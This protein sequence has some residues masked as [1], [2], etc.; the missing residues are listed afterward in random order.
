MH[1]RRSGSGRC[2]WPL[3]P[4]VRG[5][6]AEADLG[7]LSPARGFTVGGKQQ[8]QTRTSFREGPSLSLPGMAE[9]PFVYV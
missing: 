4:K 9:P 5:N 1:S 3:V 8:R 7:L 2:H 6:R